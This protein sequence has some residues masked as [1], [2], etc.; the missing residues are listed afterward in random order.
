MSNHQIQM[1][2][3]QYPVLEQFPVLPKQTMLHLDSRFA[4]NPTVTEYLF[5]L[6][7]TI[8]H[9]SRLSIEHIDLTVSFY[10]ISENLKNNSFLFKIQ[11]ASMVTL[12][13]PDGYYTDASLCEAFTTVSTDVLGGYTLTA[14]LNAITSKVSITCTNDGIGAIFDH[15]IVWNNPENNSL[16][17]STLGYLFGFRNGISYITNSIRTITSESPCLTNTIIPYIFLAMDDYL[18]TGTSR[19]GGGMFVSIGGNKKDYGS[20][21]SPFFASKQII[22]KVTLPIHPATGIVEYGQ[23]I[24][25]TERTGVLQSNSR[26]YRDGFMKL[27]KIKFCWLDPWG[28]EIDMNQTPFS[29]ILKI[30]HS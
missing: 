10:N 24:I 28:N 4:N 17:S 26:K 30:Q 29:I 9:V 27:K 5:D 12:T 7:E 25:A 6:P 18:N 14:N 20:S 15:S 19:E 13:I 8:Q 11:D 1:L 21:A 16:F 23:R 2:N 3:G 22:A